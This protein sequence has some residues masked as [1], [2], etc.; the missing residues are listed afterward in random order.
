[1]KHKLI[2]LTILVTA[3]LAHAADP[4]INSKS[5]VDLQDGVWKPVAG[6]LGGA[7]DYDGGVFRAALDLAYQQVRVDSLR[8][9]VTLL[10]TSQ[11]AL[12]DGGKLEVKV[13]SKRTLKAKLSV[14][15]ERHHRRR[16]RRYRAVLRVGR[17]SACPVWRLVHARESQDDGAF[18]P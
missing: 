12:T 8:P 17:Q 6:V 13:K 2:T 9:K 16:A 10:T 18:V 15:L 5:V 7:L 14:A 4:S 1:M 11:S 3:A